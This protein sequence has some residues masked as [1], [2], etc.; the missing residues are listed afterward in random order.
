VEE[1][2]DVIEV[3]SSADEDSEDDEQ[4]HGGSGVVPASQR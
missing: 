1:A 4:G 2:L 3:L